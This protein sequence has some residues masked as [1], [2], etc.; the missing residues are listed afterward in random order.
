MGFDFEAFKNML[1]LFSKDPLAI[2][3]L[4][5]GVESYFLIMLLQF[6]PF[7]FDLIIPYPG[8]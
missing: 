8:N 2:L 3:R 1:I 5:P 7:F 6:L 4:S